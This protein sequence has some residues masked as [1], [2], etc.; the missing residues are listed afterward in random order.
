MPRGP[1]PTPIT[2]TDDERAKRTAWVRRPTSAQ[3]L[4]MRSRIVLAAAD[5]RGNAGIAADLGITLPTVRKWRDRFADRRLAGLADEPRPGPPRTMTGRNLLGS[6]SASPRVV[7]AVSSP[8]NMSIRIERKPFTGMLSCAPERWMPTQ[9]WSLPSSPKPTCILSFSL[10]P[11]TCKTPWLIF[12]HPGRVFTGF[13]TKRE[14][15][16]SPT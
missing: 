11:R 2:V 14:I 8:S 5:G 7:P 15:N 12:N 6:C 10:L 1:T 4:A 9:S 13:C 3:R 16:V